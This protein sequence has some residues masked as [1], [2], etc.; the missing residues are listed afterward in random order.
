MIDDIL[1][2]STTCPAGGHI[3]PWCE[4]QV[5]ISSRENLLVNRRKYICHSWKRPVFDLFS[6]LLLVSMVLTTNKLLNFLWVMCPRP[7]K[8]SKHSHI[9]AC[10]CLHLCAYLTC[11]FTPV[12]SLSVEI[13][14]LFPALSFLRMH[15]Q[16]GCVSLF[17]LTSAMEIE[18]W[19]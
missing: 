17:C 8:W 4:K 14:F 1:T 2:A 10:K 5:V 7:S 9:K 13:I 11:L 12:R 18:V 15:A 19:T 16:L 3:E 6:L